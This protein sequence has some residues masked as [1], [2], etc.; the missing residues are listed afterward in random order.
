MGGLKF[1]LRFL[2]ALCDA[3]AGCLVT[4][5]GGSTKG[6]AEAQLVEGCTPVM[7]VDIRQGPGNIDIV[8]PCSRDVRVSWCKE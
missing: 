1:L 5:H 3:L 4:I 6:K 2:P 8:M 7:P